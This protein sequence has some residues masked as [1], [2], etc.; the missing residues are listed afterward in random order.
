MIKIHWIKYVGVAQQN[1][2]PR[3]V[4]TNEPLEN[5]DGTFS[6]TSQLMIKLI[7]GDNWG[8]GLFLYQ[9]PGE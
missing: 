7:L 3:G 6:V 2:L 5:G 9:I 8:G 1:V 4:S